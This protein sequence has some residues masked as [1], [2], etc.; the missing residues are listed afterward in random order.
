MSLSIEEARSELRKLKRLSKTERCLYFTGLFNSLAAEYGIKSIVVGGFAVELYTQNSYMTQDIDLVF[1]RSDIANKIL[2]DLG[3]EREGK[4]W[5]HSELQL[6]V[7]IPADMLHDADY[8]RVI[9]LNLKNGDSVYV[10]GIEDII[11]DRL[12]ACIHWKST[13][14]CEWAYRIFKTHEERLDIDYL[15]QMSKKDGTFRNL[16][17][18]L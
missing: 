8:D 5:Y 9:K 17:K 1:A 3:F 4:S 16:E 10:I 7:E 2:L 15:V 14:D 13:S 6:S 11:L 12:R 18:W